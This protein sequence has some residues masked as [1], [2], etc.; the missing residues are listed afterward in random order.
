M[1]KLGLGVGQDPSMVKCEVNVAHLDPFGAQRVRPH[2][3]PTL[4]RELGHECHA[5]NMASRV[6]IDIGV[7]ANEGDLGDVNSGLLPDF[8]TAGGHDSFADLHETAW[9]CKFSRARFMPA[10]N[11]QYASQPIEDDTVC[12]Q[13][14][15][16]R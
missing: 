8:A 4:V 9:Q 15:S 6:A 13:S 1:P 11:E 3:W 7:D 12:C 14:R 16:L 10:A 5:N 2:A